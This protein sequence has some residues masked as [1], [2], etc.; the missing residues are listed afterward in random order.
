MLLMW[1][2]SYLQS[3]HLSFRAAAEQSCPLWM[4]VSLQ[5]QASRGGSISTGIIWEP[6]VGKFKQTAKLLLST[7]TVVVIVCSESTETSRCAV[8]TGELLLET[9]KEFS[10]SQQQ[11]SIY[12][13]Y[14]GKPEPMSSWFKYFRTTA[15]SPP[16][17]T[18]TRLFQAW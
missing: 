6:V 16:T 14:S 2:D 3:G 4:A 18:S 17:G 5:A 9:H 11:T 8:T 12:I 7:Q 1:G 13:G 15:E 10:L